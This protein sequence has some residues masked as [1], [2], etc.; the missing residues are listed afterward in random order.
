MRN[1]LL[2]LAALAVIPTL[3]FAQ[4][5]ACTPGYAGGRYYRLSNCSMTILPRTR[6]PGNEDTLGPLPAPMIFPAPGSRFFYPGFNYYGYQYGFPYQPNITIVQPP[7][8]PSYAFKPWYLP[9]P[10]QPQAQ[11]APTAA[12]Q[13]NYYVE[14]PR[15]ERTPRAG[16]SVQQSRQV[17]RASRAR[18]SRNKTRVV[19]TQDGRVFLVND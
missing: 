9:S 15:V 1:L 4:A 6:P 3:A 7:R 2:L 14:A 8:I 13:I 11:P 18:P 12:P 19:I 16:F 10:G 17:R 5:G